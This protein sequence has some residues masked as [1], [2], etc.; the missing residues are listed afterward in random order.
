MTLD[1]EISDSSTTQPFLEQQKD[2]AAVLKWAVTS[3]H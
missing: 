1:D 3:F 2:I